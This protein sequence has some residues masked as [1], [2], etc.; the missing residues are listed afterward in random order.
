MTHSRVHSD[1]KP[2]FDDDGDDAYD[3]DDMHI[4]TMNT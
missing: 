1:C 2:I 3:D 4:G